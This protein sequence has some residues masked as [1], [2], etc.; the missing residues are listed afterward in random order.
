MASGVTAAFVGALD[1]EAR[2]RFPDEAALAATLA[3]HDAAARAAWPALADTID[4]ARFAAELGRRLGPDATPELLAAAKAADVF[5]AIACADGDAAAITHLERDYL[6]EVDHAARKVRA[7]ADLADEVRGHLRRVL[8]TAEPGRS[9]AIRDYAGRGDLRGYLRVIAT[10]EL[11]RLLERGRRELAVDD[12]AVF[13]RFAPANDAELSFVR[14]VT[15]DQVADALRGAL[16]LLEGHDRALLRYHL[17]DGWSIDRIAQLYGIHRATAARRLTAARERL[18]EL[19]RG[20]LA[21]RL[22]IASD[23][24]DSLVR[25]VQSKVEVTFERLLADVGDNP[26]KPDDP[27]GPDDHDE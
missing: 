20:Q 5:L 14:R 26:A 27:D 24:V 22:A 11:I 13:D 8:F 18:G 10:R 4:A 9:A 25:L 1:A 2:V 3:A 16:G 7:S 19:M 15:R 17:V 6:R 12:D 21:A 23:E